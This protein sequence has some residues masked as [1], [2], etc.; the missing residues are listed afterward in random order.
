MMNDEISSPVITR[1]FHKQ[2]NVAELVAQNDEA[3][4]TEELDKR[5]RLT[6]KTQLL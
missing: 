5:R 2:Y 3:N 4:T 1:Q 6:V